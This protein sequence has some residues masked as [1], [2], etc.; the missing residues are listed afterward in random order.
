MKT[1]IISLVLTLSLIGCFDDTERDYKG[2]ISAID[3]NAP[4][5]SGQECIEGRFTCRENKTGICIDE[6]WVEV[7][8]C[9]VNTCTEID[10]IALCM[11]D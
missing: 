6:I 9:K 3:I 8:D 10:Y 2:S 5:S 7:E 4:S 1:I 11:E